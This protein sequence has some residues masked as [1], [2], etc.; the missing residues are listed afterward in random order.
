[1]DHAARLHARARDRGVDFPVLWLVRGVL[2]PAFLVWLRLA[3]SGRELIPPEGPVILAANHRSFLDPF[4]IGCLPPPG[5][6]VHYM[7]KL[8]LFA[9]PLVAR[10]LNHLGAFPVRR[11]R[12]DDD[13]LATA[14]VLLERGA[15]VV[16][17]PEGTRRRPG[18]PGSP[19]SG[20]GRLALE[21]GAAVVPVAVAGT[22]AVRDGWRI[23]PRR[24]RLRCGPP[25]RVPR[26]EAP[27]QAL[28]GRVTDRIWTA[29]R[30]E[31]E[32]LGGEP[33]PVVPEPAPERAAA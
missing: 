26:A 21:S 31:W 6:P 19:R 3:R 8:E 27:S 33:S 7:A 28:A 22:D 4:V 5:R 1:V 20:V 23:R 16:I 9:H 15:I 2:Q 11:G 29:V 25:L 18:P 10:L 12:N 14:R 30:R 24:V 17:F 32:A 13:A